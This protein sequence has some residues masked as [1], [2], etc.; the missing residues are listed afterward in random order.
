MSDSVDLISRTNPDYVD[1]LYQQFKQDPA[2]VDERW[3]LVFAGYEF[4]LGIKRKGG[5]DRPKSPPGVANLIHSYRELGH[6]VADIDPLN[7]GPKSHPLL[8]ASVAKFKPETLEQTIDASAFRSLG[9]VPLRSLI[10]ALKDTYCRSIGVEFIHLFSKEQRE[11]L[12]ERME[13]TRNRPALDV[14][15]RKLILK[16]LIFAAGFEQF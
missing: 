11:W 6:L 13:P 8:E 10:E 3:A 16:Q 9:R 2:S 15:E 14:R 12:M 1:R 5:S 4:G 7:P